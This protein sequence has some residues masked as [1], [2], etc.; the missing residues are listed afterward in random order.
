M[1]EFLVM[2]QGSLRKL[3]SKQ[4]HINHIMNESKKQLVDEFTKVIAEA[5]K[6]AVDKIDAQMADVARKH[7]K[8]ESRKGK[9]D[10]I[11]EQMIKE[12]VMAGSQWLADL[13]NSIEK[14][15]GQTGIVYVLS[16]DE[17]EKLANDLIKE[18]IR[19]GFYHAGMKS[20]EKSTTQKRWMEKDLEVK[21]IFS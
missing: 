15:R 17:T 10:T 20:Q 8:A 9:S 18:G 7:L 3:L 11:G 6:L 13:V 21:Q 4:P 5:G 1:L 19:A 16:R 14:F 12:K 2:Q